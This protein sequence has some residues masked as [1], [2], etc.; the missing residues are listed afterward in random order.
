MSE[1]ELLRLAADKSSLTE[2]ARTALEHEIQ[3]RAIESN[4]LRIEQAEV[5]DEPKPKKAGA[6]RWAR[7]GI[8]LCVAL[9]SAIIA[10]VMLGNRGGPTFVE[11]ETKASLYLGLAAWGFSSV[12]AGRWLTLKRTWIAAIALYGIA[13]VSLALMLTVK[14]PHEIVHGVAQRMTYAAPD[15]RFSITLPGIPTVTTR[16]GA[17]YAAAEYSLAADGGMYSVQTADYAHPL[18]PSDA[19][20]ALA[21]LKESPETQATFSSEF[22]FTGG[23]FR[24]MTV[25]GH[26]GL[27]YVLVDRNRLYQVM[28]F[29]DSDSLDKQTVS[30]VITS[31]QNLEGKAAR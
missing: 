29:S 12:V 1:D 18:D 13:F 22:R 30:A 6:S 7:L 15:G 16:Q 19:D 28:F 4:P 14:S 2:P 20:L 10:G 21:A 11:A 27:Y 8:F 24:D 5:A 9:A 31:F 26:P 23:V 17:G 25:K 3:V